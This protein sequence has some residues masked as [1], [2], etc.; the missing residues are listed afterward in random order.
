VGLH[1]YT[2]ENPVD[3][4]PQQEEDVLDKCVEFVTG[5]TGKRPTGHVAPCGNSVW[6]R[7]GS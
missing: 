2:H 4:T 5:L 6:P 1:G 7:M 3:M